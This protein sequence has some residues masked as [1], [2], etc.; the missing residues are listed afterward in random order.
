MHLAEL[1]LFNFKNH[2]EG[3][4]KL[5]PGV[6]GFYGKNGVGKTNILDAIYMLSCAKSYFNNID[7]QLVR[8]EQSFF[9]LK[10]WYGAEKETEILLKFE[11]GKKNLSR[12]GK[13]YKRLIDHIGALPIVFITPYDIALVLE[14]SEERRRFIDLCI[15]QVHPEYL[16][17]LS[18]NKKVLLSRNAFLKSN[19]GQV[20]DPILLESYDKRLIETGEF[21]Y[22]CRKQFIA[23]FNNYFQDSYAHLTGGEELVSM[24]YIS[25]LNDGHY[26]QQLAK[27]LMRDLAAQRSTIGVHKDDLEFKLN[28]LGLKKFGSQGQIK[29]V[30]IAAKLAQFHY[31]SSKTIIKPLLLLDDIFEKIDLSRAHKLIEMISDPRFGQ[32]I[33]SDTERVRMEQFLK[34][35]K[36]ETKYF[37]IKQDA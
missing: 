33:V 16:R 24:T 29:S 4:Y 8:F 6:N 10:G 36:I 1:Q 11:Q 21:I 28:D 14:A 37:E 22:G 27:N 13:K 7:S 12:N 18:L 3:N 30:V 25:Q 34:L 32:I 19:E 2:K 26:A 9:S 15:S 31:F 17:S 23:E 35:M 5:C 20:I